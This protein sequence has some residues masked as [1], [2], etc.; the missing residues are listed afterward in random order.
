[1]L[2]AVLGRPVDMYTV[3]NDGQLVPV[4]RADGFAATAGAGAPG[5]A[6][7]PPVRLFY[8]ND[9][10]TSYDEHGGHGQGQRPGS[11]LLECDVWC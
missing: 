7:L 6:A 10:F 3:N 4:L 8:L 5:T 2:A 1:M 9:H 11:V